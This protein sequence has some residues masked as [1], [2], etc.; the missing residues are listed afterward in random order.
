MFFKGADS[1]DFKLFN[2]LQEGDLVVTQDY[3]LVVMYL[4]RNVK[5]ISQ[6]DTLTTL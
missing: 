6:D 2:F 3:G 4:V 1:V 5:V